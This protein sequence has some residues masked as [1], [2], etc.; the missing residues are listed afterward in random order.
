MDFVERKPAVSSLSENQFKRIDQAIQLLHSH[1]LVFGDLRPP[2]ILITGETPMII[3]FD[4]CGKAGE[5]RDPADLNTAEDLGWPMGVGPTFVIRKKEHNVF[6]LQ[7]LNPE[8]MIKSYFI[9]PTL[10]D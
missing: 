4:W 6:M 7:K 1:N 2:N 10:Y 3:D 8:Y 5:A 9:V